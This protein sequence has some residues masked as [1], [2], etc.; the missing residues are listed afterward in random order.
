MTRKLDYLVVFE[1]TLTDQHVPYD[2][3]I[4]VNDILCIDER[5]NIDLSHQPIT[6]PI[7]NSSARPQRIRIDITTPCGSFNREF[8]FDPAFCA[9]R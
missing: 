9:L 2:L 5:G 3:R 8:V 1:N 6:R 7:K 4:F